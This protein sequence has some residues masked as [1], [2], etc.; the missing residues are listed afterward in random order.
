MTREILFRGFHKE[1][2]GKETIYI[3]GQP[4]KGKWVFGCGAYNDKVIAFI[5]NYDVDLIKET[6]AFEH[7]QVI[8]E[9]IGQYTGL[10][11]KNGKKIFENDIVKGVHYKFIVKWNKNRT[12]FGLFTFMEE[13]DECIPIN[14]KE[15]IPYEVIG[16][17]FDK[18]VIK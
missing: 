4:I 2:N 10:D 12:A 14:V 13:I 1:E 15:F 5:I 9:T 11:D 3:D 6:S 17:I 16:T 18:E 7:I 8:P